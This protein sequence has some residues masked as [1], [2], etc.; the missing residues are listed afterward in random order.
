MKKLLVLLTLVFSY[1]AMAQTPGGLEGPFGDFM[2][3]LAQRIHSLE[4]GSQLRKMELNGMTTQQ[5]VGVFT[6]KGALIQS[7]ELDDYPTH[8][9][10]E[11]LGL[12]AG[13]HYLPF[14]I[15]ITSE[16]KKFLSISAME[17]KKMNS[18]KAANNSGWKYFNDLEL[19]VL[20]YDEGVNNPNTKSVKVDLIRTQFKI[21]ILNSARPGRFLAIVAGG[22]F[23]FENLKTTLPNGEEFEIHGRT[24]VD[25]MFQN[26]EVSV[27]EELSAPTTYL[28]YRGHKAM[29]TCFNVG[30]EYNL[31]LNKD[32]I[33]NFEAMLNG[34]ILR[35]AHLTDQ[36]IAEN[37]ELNQG[38]YLENNQLRNDQVIALNDWQT[39]KAIWEQNQGHPV[40]TYSDETYANL[41][42]N[43][44]PSNMVKLKDYQAV[45]IKEVTSSYLYISPNLTL[46]KKYKDGSGRS[47]QLNVYGNIPLKQGVNID[48]VEIDLTGKTARPL[49]GAGIKINF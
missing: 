18:T 24:K 6:A 44:I 7:Y 30:L 34:G 45:K 13:K 37:K 26:G 14:T 15:S 23:G 22:S 3:G 8:S 39:A 21:D 47:V 16:G 33:L 25:N 17:W 38:I 11:N 20:Q 43:P 1:F 32:L 2:S 36:E 10:K 5:F 31:P 19:I 27:Q 28:D 46:T 41:S 9:K 42:G 4:I 49:L 40:G 29:S 35:G 12:G 48:G